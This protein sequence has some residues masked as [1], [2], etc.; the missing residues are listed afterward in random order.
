MERDL[1]TGLGVLHRLERNQAASLPL[2]PGLL[3]L[4]FV[5]AKTKNCQDRS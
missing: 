2:G 3:A 5:F 1:F 4:R